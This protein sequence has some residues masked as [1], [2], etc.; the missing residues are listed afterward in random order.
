[1]AEGLGI[2][3]SALRVLAF[4]ELLSVLLFLIPRTA[5]VGYILLVAYMGGA[6]SAHLITG[7]SLA[8][9]IVIQVLL[10]IIASLRIP[11]L[12]GILKGIVARNEKSV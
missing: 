11:E 8:F 12:K 6:I 1:M 5:F 10:C 9:P 3:L 7:E 2:S 4:I